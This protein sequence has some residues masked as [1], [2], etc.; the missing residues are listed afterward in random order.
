MRYCVDVRD[1][2]PKEY[3]VL[4]KRENTMAKRKKKKTMVVKKRYRKLKDW[5]TRTLLKMGVN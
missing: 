3:R 5:T 2:R 1:I 4:Q